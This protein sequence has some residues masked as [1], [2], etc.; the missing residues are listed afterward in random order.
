MLYAIIV[1]FIILDVISGIFKAAYQGNLNSK[2]MRKGLMYKFSYIIVL[3]LAHL[4]D[5]GAIYMD[6]GFSTNTFQLASVFVCTTETVSIVENVLE[7][8]PENTAEKLRK[9]FKTGEKKQ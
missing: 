7:I 8:M 2:A 3:A 4:I 9:I 5:Y 1:G 6:I